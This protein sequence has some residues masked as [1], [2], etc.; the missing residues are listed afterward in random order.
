MVGLSTGA[1][2]KRARRHHRDALVHQG[3]ADSS[4]AVLGASNATGQTALSAGCGVPLRTL[5]L[6][7]RDDAGGD[8]LPDLPCPGA[9]C[10]ARTTRAT[11]DL[12]SYGEGDRRFRRPSRF[13][14]GNALQLSFAAVGRLPPETGPSGSLQSRSSSAAWSTSG[15]VQKPFHPASATTSE[16]ERSPHPG[17]LATMGRVRLRGNDLFGAGFPTVTKNRWLLFWYYGLRGLSLLMLPYTDFSLYGLSIFAVFYGLDWIANGAPDSEADGSDVRGG[18]KGSAGSSGWIFLAHQMGA[19]DRRLRGRS[20][21]G[22]CCSAISL[23]SSRAGV[24]C[25][26]AS[27]AVAD[28]SQAD[29]RKPSSRPPAE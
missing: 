5:R 23:L 29:N 15:L 4:S 22:T 10:R 28:D 25:I 2:A 18:E 14:G 20:I 16:S 19:A 6:A 13:S 11:V 17:V 12:P 8:A 7:L 26:I 9:H 27:A 21:P 24:V 3:G 1:T